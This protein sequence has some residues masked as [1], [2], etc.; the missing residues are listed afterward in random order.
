MITKPKRRSRRGIWE[1][2]PQMSLEHSYLVHC[3]RESY[4]IHR[5]KQIYSKGNEPPC[6][7]NRMCLDV[8]NP[9]SFAFL[10]K[11]TLMGFDSCSLT[12]TLCCTVIY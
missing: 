5:I 8:E 1:D 4:S 11:V 7:N 2:V 10:Q 9:L 6:K 3:P 12:L